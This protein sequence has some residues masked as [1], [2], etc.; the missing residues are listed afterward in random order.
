[1]AVDSNYSSVSLL[2]HCDGTNGSTTFTDSGPLVKSVTNT[3]SLTVSTTQ[4]KFGGASALATTSGKYLTLDGSSAFAF[5]TG[6]FTIEFWMWRISGSGAQYII[7]NTPSGSSSLH[8]QIFC[9]PSNFLVYGISSTG[10]K[11][12]STSAVS[13]GAWHHIAV[14]RSGSSTKLFIDGT[15]SGSTYTGSDNLLVGANRPIIGQ[16]GFST[17]N[18]NGFNGYLDDIRITKGVARYTTSFTPP[19]SAFPNYA[20]EPVAYTKVG[21]SSVS[22]IPAAPSM[23]II[24]AHHLVGSS[25][26]LVIP[27]SSKIYITRNHS[28]LS[29]L[30]VE[31]LPLSPTSFHATYNP[32]R[33]GNVSI[34]VTPSST[35][36]FHT[37]NHHRTGNVIVGVLPSSTLLLSITHGVTINELIGVSQSLLYKE[38][39]NIFESIL[40]SPVSLPKGVFKSLVREYLSSL[41]RLL[42][43]F[44]V[45][46]SESLAYSHSLTGIIHQLEYIVENTSLLLDES[47]SR[48]ALSTITELIDLVDTLSFGIALSIS[49]TIAL[50][51]TL[52]SL[53]KLASTL[54]EN[55]ATHEDHDSTYIHIVSLSEGL[56]LLPAF[57]GSVEFYNALLDS[58]VI[59][60]PSATGQDTYLAYLLNTETNSVSTY[61]NYSFSCST[62]FNGKYL[63]GNSTGLY[64]YGGTTDAG[65]AIEARVKT[66]AY[67][68]GTS[69]LKQVPDMYIGGVGS[70]QMV[71]KVSVDNK[72]SVYYKVTNRIKDLHTQRVKFGKGLIGRYFQ[73]EL[74]TNSTDTDLES[75]EF[76]P[77]VLHRKI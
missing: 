33:F 21:S 4:S 51:S 13:S 36:L 34:S 48:H 23:H 49:E 3:G 40:I 75:I 55:I 10:Q 68:F 1:M 27:Y 15:Q 12:T 53:G 47:I 11:I 57:S 44:K 26:L 50:Q 76:Y 62:L 65:E 67:S 20:V 17:G 39:N 60:I 31:V 61:T 5:G 45:S 32:I 16:F 7:D 70:D 35:L 9:D 74:I 77:V 58:F 29:R 18:P 22:V 69:N 73:F 19:T 54:L 8:P 30:K 6:D 59:S 2:L 24:W 43:A 46:I 72:A 25:S 38:I 41:D 42:S 71:V 37:P 66:L 63:L 52:V 14:C 64:G 56:S 28:L